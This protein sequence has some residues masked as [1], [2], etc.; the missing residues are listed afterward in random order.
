MN[1]RRS[2]LL[3]VY[4]NLKVHLIK[5]L[6]PFIPSKINNSNPINQILHN[7]KNY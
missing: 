1:L 3:I 7:M 6:L 2:A 5:Y 4:I